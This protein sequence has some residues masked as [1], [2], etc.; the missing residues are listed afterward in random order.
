M[1]QFTVG[2]SEDPG[3][4]LVERGVT[5]MVAEAFRIYRR[6]WREFVWMS[7][8]VHAPIA[9]IDQLIGT[10]AWAITL[11]IAL[12]L[13]GS[14]AFFGAGVSAVCQHYLL[15]RVDVGAA[16]RRA[17]WRYV[18]ILAV[19][20]LTTGVVVAGALLVWIIVPFVAAVVYAIYWSVAAPAVIVEGHK[21]LDAL[22]RSY[23]LVRGGWLRTFGAAAAFVLVAVGLSLIGWIPYWIADRSGGAESSATVAFRWIGQMAAAV[24][25]PPI[26]A[27]CW[28]LLYYDIRI[29]KEELSLARLSEEL[30]MARP[31]GPP[32][33]SRAGVT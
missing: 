7:A 24:G 16:Y 13:L 11:V 27:I 12:S 30:G 25:V 20:V 9:A 17:Q 8:L 31:G 15:G 19:T 29:R 10:G 22:K 1:S 14:A 23:G 2:P 33:A 3:G 32:G 26:L 4:P 5:E 21:P 18:S 28:T 6:R